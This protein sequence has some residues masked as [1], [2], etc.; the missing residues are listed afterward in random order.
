MVTRETSYIGQLYFGLSTD[1]TSAIEWH[2]GDRILL[3][4]QDQMYIYDEAAATFHE[5]PMG[6]G[7]GGGGGS[8]DWQLLASGTYTLAADQN[9]LIAIPAP[10]TTP[11]TVKRVYVVNKAAS[12]RSTGQWI[13][14][15]RY[16]DNPYVMDDYSMSAPVTATMLT[17]GGDTRW[18][19]RITG[20][21][22]VP[23]W[24]TSDTI[25]CQRYD[26]NT[27][28]YAGDYDWYI[29]GIPT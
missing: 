17:S 21:I 16:Y 22:N 15:V 19:A 24:Y 23:I 27:K 6:G 5:I 25:S 13:S 7:G 8:G 1:D 14:L 26:S 18:Y 4:D 9:S 12:Q 11:G 29:W 3:M 10:L 20:N 2:N 28:W